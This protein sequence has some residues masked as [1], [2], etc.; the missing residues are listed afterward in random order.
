VRRALDFVLDYWWAF[1][2]GAIVLFF[3]ALFVHDLNQPETK[4]DAE[5]EPAMKNVELVAVS[6]SFGC[7]VYRAVDDRGQV[8]YFGGNDCGGVALGPVIDGGGR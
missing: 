5:Y 4:R 3:L 7:F 2:I 6:H 1:G 8:I